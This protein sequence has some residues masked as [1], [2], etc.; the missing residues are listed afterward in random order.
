MAI[1][2][3]TLTAQP[4][5]PVW[6]VGD[7]LAKAREFADL[8]Q[9]QMA[10]QLCISRRSIVRH[11]TAATPPRSIVLAYASVTK[12]PVWWLEGYDQDT[13]PNTQRYSRDDIMTQGPIAA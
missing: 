11:E 13:M 10:D 6:T 9:Q 4:L 12:V 7:R 2:T 3:D 5:L 1:M 8:S